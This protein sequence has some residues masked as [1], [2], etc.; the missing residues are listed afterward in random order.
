MDGGL[1]G[2]PGKQS[3][4]CYTWWTLAAADLAGASLC[5]LFRLELLEGF[6]MRCVTDRGLFT[7][8]RL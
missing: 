7:L 2:R 6:V 8:H 3:D 4:A 1:N 5:E